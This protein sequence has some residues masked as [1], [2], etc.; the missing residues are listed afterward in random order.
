M[1][2]L[3][4][5]FQREVQSIVEGSGTIAATR[6]LLAIQQQGPRAVLLWNRR[7][8]FHASATLSLSQKTISTS[9]AAGTNAVIRV[10]SD[11]KSDCSCNIAAEFKEATTGEPGTVG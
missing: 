6:E 9:G 8:G 10:H 2:T 4:S 11:R 7:Y 3:A 5:R 1:G